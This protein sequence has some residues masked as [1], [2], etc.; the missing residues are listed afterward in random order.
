MDQALKDLKDRQ[1]KLAPK[2]DANAAL[3]MGD[4]C[5][6]NMVGYM[7]DESGGKGEPLPNA[8]EEEQGGARRSAVTTLCTM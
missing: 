4:A 2:G 6:V 1:A 8:G 7:A 5:V 3:E